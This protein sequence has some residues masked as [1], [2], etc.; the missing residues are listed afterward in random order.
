MLRYVMPV[1]V[2][3]GMFAVLVNHAKDP[4]S[5]TDTY[6]HLRFGHEF[7]HGA[8]SLWRPG[9]RDDLRHQRLGADPV[10]ARRS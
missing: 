6:F 4:L 1:L 8:W 2:V 10:A 5:N 7:L 9:Q 3:V